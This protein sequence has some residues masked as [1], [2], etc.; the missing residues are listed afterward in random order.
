MWT[1]AASG[2]RINRQRAGPAPTARPRRDVRSGVTFAPS[3][4]AL[5]GAGARQAVRWETLGERA[6]AGD[7]GFLLQEKL[8]PLLLHNVLRRTG[9]R[10][11]V[12]VMESNYSHSFHWSTVFIEWLRWGQR[13]LPHGFLRLRREQAEC[14]VAV[15]EAHSEVY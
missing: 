12:C 7:A 11:T 3:G 13:R 9:A 14:A 4:S 10:S 5:A 8:C 2:R 15:L 6:G 1:Q